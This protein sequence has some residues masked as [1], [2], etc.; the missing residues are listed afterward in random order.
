MAWYFWMVKWVPIIIITV[1]V[2]DAVYLIHDMFSE[3]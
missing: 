3:V 1:S 2:L